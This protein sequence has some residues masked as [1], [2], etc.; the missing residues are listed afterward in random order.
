MLDDKSNMAPRVGAVAVRRAHRPYVLLAL[1]T[2]V[3]YSLWRWDLRPVTWTASTGAEA[4]RSGK[5]SS[6]L[7]ALEAHI[8]SKCPDAK[9]SA[10]PCLS[11]VW[12][13]RRS[14]LLTTPL[15]GL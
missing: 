6:E 15:P 11:G 12:R 13:S 9:V 5:A 2:L 10:C 4:P 14:S 7:V 8:M 1:I 3:F